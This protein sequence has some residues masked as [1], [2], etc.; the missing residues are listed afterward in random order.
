[1]RLWVASLTL[2]FT[3]FLSV[4]GRKLT[5]EENEQNE[6]RCGVHFLGRQFKQNEYPWTVVLTNPSGARLCSGVQISPRH[7]LTAAHCALKLDD[8]FN[9]L[10]CSLN[11]SE[12]TV[13]VMRNPEEI[14]VAIG[15]NKEDTNSGST[16]KNFKA[17]HNV[18]KVTVHN[19]DVCQNNNDLALIELSRNISEAH[20]T[21][22]CMPS[23][24]LQLHG[25]L[26][27]SGSGM[28]L[29]AQKYYGVDE[30][31]HK[32]LTLTF[33][34]SPQSGD[35]GGPLFQVD[36][37]EVHTLVGITSTGLPGEIRQSDHGRNSLA[38][39]TDVRAFI[40]WICKYSGVCPVEDT[41][42]EEKPPLN[43]QN[44]MRKDQTKL[45]TTDV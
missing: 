13:S 21:P 36:E 40:D 27:A 19:Y 34:K 14:F 31:S 17:L 33:S 25:V 1:M 37:A 6:E 11:R 12:S 35:S 26:Y 10:Q 16:S 39:Y 7:I 32:I 22:I 18:S 15:F 45:T 24:N 8:R 9:N 20:S 29:V 41:S 5:T 43:P 38:Y 2:L 44:G 30:F 23:E 28:D 3:S 42:L 4:S